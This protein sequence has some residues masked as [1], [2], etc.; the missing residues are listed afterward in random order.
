MWCLLRLNFQDIFFIHLMGLQLVWLQ[1]PE[2]G[3]SG[4]TAVKLTKASILTLVQFLGPL[5]SLR[6]SPS[7][8]SFPVGFPRRKLDFLQSALKSAKVERPSSDSELSLAQSHLWLILLILVKTSHR[9]SPHSE[10]RDCTRICML[11]CVIHWR[12][13]IFKMCLYLS[14]ICQHGPS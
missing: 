2:T 8:W 11:R 14:E 4:L 12:L 5:L 3:W 13:P 6:A 10:K 1:L 9:L 7:T